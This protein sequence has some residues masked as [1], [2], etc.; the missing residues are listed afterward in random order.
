LRALQGAV[1]DEDLRRGQEA[2]VGICRLV[3][4][5]SSCGRS[6]DDEAAKIAVTMIPFRIPILL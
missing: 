4:M 2:A 6:L 1:S 3:I 5:I